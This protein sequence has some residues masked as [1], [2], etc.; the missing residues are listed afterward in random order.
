MIAVDANVISYYF[1]SGE[2]TG[3][4]EKVWE[5]DP[6]WV[7]PVFWRIEFLN[8]ISKYCRFN[9]MTLDEARKLFA[10][11]LE[12]LS[13]K[14]SH[15]DAEYVL[16]LS[17]KNNVTVYDAEYVSLAKSLG[18]KLV[19]SDKELLE[20]FPETAISMENFAKSSDF[21]FIKEKKAGYGDGLSRGKLKK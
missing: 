13:E 17:V 21:K 14:E 15:T 11:A 19:T 1:I 20:K 3:L 4:S 9:G 8:V 18:I 5:R 10:D 6:E 2:K 7:V 12:I 16:E